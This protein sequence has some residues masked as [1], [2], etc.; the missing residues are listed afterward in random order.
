MVDLGR[1]LSKESNTLPTL[2]ALEVSSSIKERFL[3]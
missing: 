2:Q 3:K 1:I